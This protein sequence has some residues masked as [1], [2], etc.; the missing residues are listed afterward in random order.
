M[1]T[2]R[3]FTV[4]ALAFTL[5][6]CAEDKKRKEREDA[7][8]RTKE[9][10]RKNQREIDE[11]SSGRRTIPPRIDIQC[12]P[13][14]DQKVEIEGRIPST[15]PRIKLK[16]PMQPGKANR[17]VFS[18]AD[19]PPKPNIDDRL[20]NMGCSNELVKKYSSDL[21]VVTVGPDRKRSADDKTPSLELKARVI[22]LCGNSSSFDANFTTIHSNTLVMNGFSRVSPLAPMSFPG[23]GLPIETD[24][25]ILQGDNTYLIQRSG[26]VPSYGFAQE[27]K[28]ALDRIEGDGTLTIDNL[29]ASC[30]TQTGN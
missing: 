21:Q 6:A 30:P 2:L 17:L 24:R 20:I 28:I 15:E 29:G 8:E 26:I 22:L 10:I 3:L 27:L 25:L 16:K 23:I 7:L 19:L 12:Y 13:S 1:R 5:A 18:P 9:Q 11:I 4:I 14:E